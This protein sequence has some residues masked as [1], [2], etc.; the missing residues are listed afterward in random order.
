[1]CI[2]IY[3]SVY[4]YI[5]IYVQPNHIATPHELLPLPPRQAGQ[6]GESTT[7]GLSI[8]ARRDAR[9]AHVTDLDLTVFGD[10]LT[11]MTVDADGYQFVCTK[12]ALYLICPKNGGR[13]GPPDSGTTHEVSGWHALLAGH[14]SETGYKD[15]NGPEARFNNPGGIAL[16]LDHNVLL[17]DTDNH[18]LRKVSRTGAV[19]TVAGSGEGGYADGV[20]TAAQF[21]RPWGIVV[22]AHGT[23]FI[24]DRDN[25]CLR[26]VAPADGTVSTLAG[27]GQ[28]GWSAKQF[29]MPMGLALD[30]DSHLIVADS[31]NHCIRRVTTDNGGVTKV[32]GKPEHPGSTDGEDWRLCALFDRPCGIAVD[33]DN[34]VLV[35]DTNNSAI[36]CVGVFFLERQRYS[37]T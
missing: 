28:A 22:D 31:G 29:N 37:T 30:A 2:C 13:S 21:H 33:G 16:D 3:L 32:A 6:A 10:D 1:M 9:D 17:A 36:R 35:A 20:G 14:K 11:C 4:I 24:A 15:G 25:H 34:N 7:P 8:P 18:A 5:Y 27:T 12:S 23:I 19:T 26:K